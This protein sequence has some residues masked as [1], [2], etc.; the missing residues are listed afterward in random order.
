MGSTADF[1]VGFVTAGAFLFCVAFI[2][3]V[4]VII[5]PFLRRRPATPGDPT[6]STGTSSSPASMRRS[7]SRTPPAA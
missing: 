3:Y 7:S 6:P 1:L 2:G 5:I 4:A